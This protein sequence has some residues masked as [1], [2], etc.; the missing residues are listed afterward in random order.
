MRI[1]ATS[2]LA[3]LLLP[4]S[5]VVSVQADDTGFITIHELRREGNLLCTASHE[6]TGTGTTQPNKKLAIR[7]AAKSWSEFTNW[8]YGTDWGRW[9]YARGKSVSCEGG[10]GAMSCTVIARPCK[11]LRRR[12]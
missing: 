2:V 6:H 7:S 11:P 12:R 3:A 4:L 8:E 9:R 1:R 10:K 5:G